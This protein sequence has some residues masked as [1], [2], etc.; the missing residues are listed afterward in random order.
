MKDV[1]S[2]I[3]DT[4]ALRA[5]LYF[6]TDFYP[7]FSVA[8]PV[9]ERAA[10]FHLAVQGDCV[11]R[12]G[13]GSC[14]TLRPGD[15][16][17]IPNGSAHVLESGSGYATKPV[18]KAVAIPGVADNG[19]F[20]VG[21]GPA[22]QSCQLVCGHFNF[23]DG[24]DHP[25]LRAMPDLLHITA[26]DR[27]Q[28]PMLD[29]VV[30]L[31]ARRIFAGDAGTSASVSRLSEVLF[32][33]IMRL[34]VSQAPDI[35]RVMSAVYDPQ[36][37]RALTLIHNDVASDWT[38]ESLAKAVAMSRSG[39]A[40]RFRELVGSAPM[41]YLAE[42]RLQR[43][44]HLVSVNKAPI[45]AIAAQVG[46]HSAAAF[47]RAFSERFGYPPTKH[48][49]RESNAATGD[50]AGDVADSGDASGAGD[51]SGEDAPNAHLALSD[52]H[53]ALVPA[54]ASGGPEPLLRGAPFD[55]RRS[56]AG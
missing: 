55:H 31:I 4:V 16:A 48:L 40:G 43:A 45:K 10:R 37:G 44:L 35:G 11:V 41:S 38:V 33:E 56:S 52:P 2:D 34:G 27:A 20:V 14:V 51:A 39:F 15:L 54:G 6:R 1:L 19:A 42:W 7:P 49:S 29:D 26:A 18:A 8:V 13:D 50:G 23:A 47:T 46:F 36:I 53:G 28:H 22:S 30:G 3:L 32:I 17:L 21:E 24:A 12:L 9:F 25:L 5:A